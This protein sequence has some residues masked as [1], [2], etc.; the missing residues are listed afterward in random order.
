MR[1]HDVLRPTGAE[2]IQGD[3]NDSAAAVV[4]NAN[5]HAHTQAVRGHDVLRP[6]VAEPIQWPSEPPAART[7]I[8]MH[9]ELHS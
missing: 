4:L 6:T 3:T 5:R 2:P 9:A 7:D 8:W 1:G